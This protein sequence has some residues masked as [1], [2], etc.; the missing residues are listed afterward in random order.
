MQG[1]RGSSRAVVR[2]LLGKN[3]CICG[4]DP[5][6][7]RVVVTQSWSQMV[8]LYFKYLLCRDNRNR[9][10]RE[11][12]GKH[13]AWPP[14]VFS[15]SLFQLVTLKCSF[16]SPS[17]TCSVS[18]LPCTFPGLIKMIVPKASRLHSRSGALQQHLLLD[19][20]FSWFGDVHSPLW[21]CFPKG[22]FILVR[23]DFAGTCQPLRSG[24]KSEREHIASGCWYLQAS[25][26]I[27]RLCDLHCVTEDSRCWARCPFI[28]SLTPS[29]W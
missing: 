7:L 26:L 18:W 28:P 3:D 4:K 20:S 5:V 24:G 13:V 19:N 12:S 10:Q 1:A 15:F 8:S 17:Q 25:K 14:A 21:I 29:G 6:V 9:F 22:L 11:A 16:F 27:R 2:T 23:M